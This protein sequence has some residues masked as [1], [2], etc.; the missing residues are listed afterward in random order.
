M[1]YKPYVFRL[2]Q[3]TKVAIPATISSL[4]GITE[5]AVYGVLIPKK[6]LY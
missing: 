4:L 3:L 2:G 1:S 5:P 6:N